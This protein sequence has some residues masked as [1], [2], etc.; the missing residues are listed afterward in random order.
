[1]FEQHPQHN[2]INFYETILIPERYEK[3][4]ERER[5]KE[6]KREKREK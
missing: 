4:R 6:K 2:I 3:R 5:N 1:M